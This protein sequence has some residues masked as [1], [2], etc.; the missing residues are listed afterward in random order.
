MNKDILAG[1]ESEADAEL[2]NRLQKMDHPT[3]AAEK[4]NVQVTQ[5]KV[6]AR[7]QRT[8]SAQKSWKWIL[9][10]TG[11]VVMV[12]L[13]VTGIMAGLLRN[14]Q[15]VQAASLDNLN[16]I[17]EI[18]KDAGQTWAVV[19]DGEELASGDGLRTYADS[20]VMLTFPDG[21]V[22]QVGEE[23]EVFVSTLEYQKRVLTLELLQTAGETTH[24]VVPVREGGK[25]L[26]NT[27]T[28]TAQVHGT[29]FNVNVPDAGLARFAV[30]DGLVEVSNDGNEIL[31][32]AGQV[33]LAEE[34]G[35]LVPAAYDFSLKG[36]LEAIGTDGTWMVSGVTFKVTEDTRLKGEFVVGDFIHVIGRVLDSGE[37]VAD[38]IM[39]SQV[40]K[41]I[42]C[43]SGTVESISETEWVISGQSVVVNSDTI[44]G[45]GLEVGSL[46]EVR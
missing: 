39:Y 32:A 42:L 37:R 40:D 22:V 15:Q 44:L 5:L 16:G 29:V 19:E 12:T 34:D 28:G 21:S 20:S 2:V 23:A 30:T 13:V 24:W 43:F 8:A 35:S 7:A 3:L 27:I 11:T 33:T 46:V 25:Y 1:I 31:L 17:V 38:M 45:E 18:S 4:A 36:E 10:V 26:V 6:A 14:V 41:E 9:A